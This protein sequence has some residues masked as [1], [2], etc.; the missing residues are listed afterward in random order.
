MCVLCSIGLAVHAVGAA[1]VWLAGLDDL[2]GWTP[3]SLTVTGLLWPVLMVAGI[4]FLRIGAS[5]PKTA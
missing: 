3:M 2:F 4:V 5:Q 1:F